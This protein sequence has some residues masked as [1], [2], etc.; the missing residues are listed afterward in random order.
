MN[1]WVSYVHGSDSYRRWTRLLFGREFPFNDTLEVW[2]LL[3]AEDPSLELIDYMCV[4]MILRI[5]WQC[6]VNRRVTA[7]WC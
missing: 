6:K 1:L 7:I 5:R 2:D 3:F 4:A